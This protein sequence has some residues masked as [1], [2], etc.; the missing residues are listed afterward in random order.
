MTGT[1]TATFDINCDMGE[2]LGNWVMGSDEE[3]MPHITT[4]N[5]ACGFH[6]GDPVTMQTTVALA[7]RHGVAV[8]AHPGFPDLLGFGRRRM[9]LSPE[10]AA[11]YVTFQTGALRGFL[12]AA[13]MSLHHI[14]AHGAFFT[15]LR[16]ED[17]M[18]EPVAK[19]IAAFGDD[20][21]L[22][23]PAPAAGVAFCEAVE[24]EGVEIVEEIYPDL[25]YAP[26]GKLVV[27]RHKRAAD[28]DFA[29]AQVTQFLKEGTVTA[30][31][32]S[33]VALPGARSAC[34]HG[35]A[36]NA[37]AVAQAVGAAAQAAGRELEAVTHA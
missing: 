7:A 4:A 25:T 1:H 8:G 24:A 5:V 9:E 26:D 35:D 15:L 31:D 14:K 28:L 21:M 6:G 17:A 27:E 33:T 36:A 20:V 23:W 10:D 13:G 18:A 29:A 37:V 19:A 11:A 2:S 34:V 22:Y 16:D 32:G 3:I 12:D 30:N